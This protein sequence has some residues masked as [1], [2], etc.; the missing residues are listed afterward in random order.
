MTHGGINMKIGMIGIGDIAKKAYL[1]ILTT[2]KNV[3][4]ILCSRNQKTLDH[5]KEQYKSVKCVLSVDALI[6]HNIDAAF[7]HAVTH[8]HYKIVKQL[9]LSGIH[10]YVDKPV[11]YAISEVRE[12]FALAK[13]KN[14]TFRVGFNRRY[15]PRVLALEDEE[16][17]HLIV[18]QKNRYMQPANIRNFIL[19]DFIH[20]VDTLRHLSPST[21]YNLTA[22]GKI[23]KELLHS[24]NISLTSHNFT[25][26]GIM[27]RQS[28]RNEEVIEYMCPNKKIVINNL[29][30]QRTYEHNEEKHVA[31]SDW[32]PTLERRGFD[33]II[34]TFLEDIRLQVGFV[35]KDLDSLKSHEICETIIN[36]L[37]KQ[38]L[39]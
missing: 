21:T 13:D 29:N 23:E 35:D 33:A 6:K 34:F 11:S 28:G 36:I 7:V 8:V 1:P 16:I 31:F 39:I 30:S 27:N 24:V 38:I 12:L 32:M 3:E 9:L 14:L 25:A 10:V 20:V 2:T 22:S 18:Y 19:D 37:T 26:I 4:L 17:P 15:T 5:L